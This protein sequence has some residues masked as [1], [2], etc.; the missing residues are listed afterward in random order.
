M[1]KKHNIYVNAILFIFL[2]HFTHMR[3]VSNE[4]YAYDLYWQ[5]WKVMGNDKPTSQ[6]QKPLGFRLFKGEHSNLKR[7]ASI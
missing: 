7:S 4:R 1:V 2:T 3:N 6:V 5:M